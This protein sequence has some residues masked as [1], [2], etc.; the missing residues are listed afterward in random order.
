MVRKKIVYFGK[1][2]DILPVVVRLINQNEQ[3]EGLGTNSDEELKELCT[4]TSVD[5][6]LFGPGIEEKN[7][8]DIRSFLSSNHPKI[9]IIQHYGGGSGLLSTEIWEAL[10]K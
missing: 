5:L 1:N 6:V 4:N 10:G 7:E 9:Q 2:L 3:W 8:R